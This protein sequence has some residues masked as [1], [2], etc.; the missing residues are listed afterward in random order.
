MPVSYAEKYVCAI[1]IDWTFL[2]SNIYTDPTRVV[3]VD[4]SLRN[5][6][7]QRRTNKVELQFSVADIRDSLADTIEFLAPPSCYTVGKSSVVVD[8][9]VET[10]I[11]VRWGHIPFMVTNPTS[12]R[13]LP[14]VE[15]VPPPGTFPPRVRVIGAY[16]Q[17]KAH[18][19]DNLVIEFTR[20]LYEFRKVRVTL[21][22]HHNILVADSIVALTYD[23][24]RLREIVDPQKSNVYHFPVQDLSADLTSETIGSNS[25]IDL[26][27]QD[28]NNET[29]TLLVS[30]IN[31]ILNER[32]VSTATAMERDVRSVH[33]SRISVG[34]I[35]STQGY[36][37]T[38]PTEPASGALS[39]PDYHFDARNL[40]EASYTAHPSRPST[41]YLS[42]YTGFEIVHPSTASVADSLRVGI[43]QPTY[44]VSM[45]K[46]GLGANL[47]DGV[48]NV[49]D[50]FE[51]TVPP[52]DNFN[53]AILVV[54]R[55]PE[56]SNVRWIK[57]TGIGV[58]GAMFGISRYGGRNAI[59]V[60]FNGI[61]IT[62]F[63]PFEWNVSN[64]FIHLVY[65]SVARNEARA[66]YDLYFRLIS[67]DHTEEPLFEDTKVF[68]IPFDSVSQ[69]HNEAGAI[70]MGIDNTLTRM[71]DDISSITLGESR[72]YKRAH[73]VEERE[74]IIASAMVDWQLGLFQDDSSIKQLY[75]ADGNM[76]SS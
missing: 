74:Y 5:T 45:K 13:L 65:A 72:I 24:A 21:T 49:R 41:F 19:S 4:I 26:Y 15:N 52:T 63:I 29:N 48:A 42:A 11:V 35:Q 71:S 30:E 9:T 67:F 23:E 20:T 1:D 10:V 3:H 17:Q 66:R 54:F 7:D 57:L 55:N 50:Y 73:T 44:M 46:V 36:Q 39:P 16:V 59:A 75:D 27:L 2:P 53:V 34:K 40:S 33:R 56:P 60:Q 32:M 76:R 61:V 6:T 37:P 28:D 25:W 62:Q 22:L 12:F 14:S 51:M 43:D 8:D 68:N 70:H 31:N 18:S 64:R 38:R 69:Y 58:D 47:P